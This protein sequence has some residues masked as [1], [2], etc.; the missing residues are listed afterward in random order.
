MDTW[1]EFCFAEIAE[2]KSP[3]FPPCA[4]NAALLPETLRDLAQQIH[5]QY[6]HAIDTHAYC[7]PC[8]LGGLGLHN[9]Y[10]G[11][12]GKA[13]TQLI[14]CIV[15][16]VASMTFIGFFVIFCLGVWVLIDAISV[17]ADASGKK[18]Q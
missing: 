13:M 16:I 12:T 15:G 4:S 11:Y 2:T 7:W 18:F 1:S 5:R 9:F 8:F 17:T 3:T 14:T 6:H 10:A